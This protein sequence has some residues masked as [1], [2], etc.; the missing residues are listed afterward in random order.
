MIV[1]P[2]PRSAATPFS[3]HRSKDY[4]FG[5]LFVLQLEARSTDKALF[6]WELYLGNESGN[7]VSS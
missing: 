2:R 1:V 6:Y 4:I 3:N 7:Q 5:I